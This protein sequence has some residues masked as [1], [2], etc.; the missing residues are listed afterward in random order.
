[1]DF[2]QK[3]ESILCS[4]AG[5]RGLASHAPALPLAQVKKELFT[6]KHTVILTGFPVQGVQ[7]LVGET[8]GP[9]GS[10]HLAAALIGLG[11]RVTVVT[12]KTSLP[13]VK[14]AFAQAAPGADVCCIATG[15]NAETLLCS[16]NPTHMIALERP[17]K[18]ADG[19]F[20]SM[21][22]KVLDAAVTETDS[23]FA[24]AK[25][26]KVVTIAVGDGGNELGMGALYNTVCRCVPHGEKIA[27]VQ[28]ADYTLVSGVSNWWGW[29]IAAL[30]STAAGACMLP[31]DQEDTAVLCAVVAAG[32]VDGCSGKSSLSVDGIAQADHLAVLRKLRK[33]VFQELEKQ[34]VKIT[35]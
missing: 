15:E 27:A 4:D 25:K 16:L 14:A 30:L 8:D 23:L 26:K 33:A 3:L 35:A 34:E 29:G 11:K 17:G 31:T 32:A 13:M 2:Y 5:G 20:Y 18:A 9:V 24:A 6:A 28:K 22:G 10:A 19:H 1:M 12:D 21:R 7:G